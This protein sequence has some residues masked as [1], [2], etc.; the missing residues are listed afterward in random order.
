MRRKS[1]AVMAVALLLCGPWLG[2]WTVALLAGAGC[3]F[4]A[5]DALVARVSHPEYV[6]FARL[7]RIAGDDR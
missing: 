5:A 1:F 6:L 4:R 3:C 7:G 2:W